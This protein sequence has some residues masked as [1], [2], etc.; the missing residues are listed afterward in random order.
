[1][2]TV[3]RVEAISDSML[4][5]TLTGCQCNIIILNAH[6]S[7]KDKS[8]D[9]KDSFYEELDLAF[10]QF[11]K[12]CIKTFLGNFNTKVGRNI[13][14]ST[15]GHKS[16]HKIH[17]DNGVRIVNFATTK[18]LSGVQCPRIA[19]FK[20]TFQLLMGKCTIRFIMS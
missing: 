10:Y 19:T 7:T 6:A 9:M 14:K 16:L 12:Y 5:V 18:N 15:T 2:T 17:N 13:F 1:M 3:Q 11:P 4:Y 8:D 20:N